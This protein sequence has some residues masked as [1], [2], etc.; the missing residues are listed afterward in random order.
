MQEGEQS[1]FTFTSREA[2]GPVAA[3]A[4]SFPCRPARPSS[5]PARQPAGR[6]AS[7]G[8]PLPSRA[9][10]SRRQPAR[11]GPAR[12]LTTGHGRTRHCSTR[13]GRQPDPAYPAEYA[14]LR[15]PGLRHA[16]PES[17]PPTGSTPVKGRGGAG[18]GQEAGRRGRSQRDTTAAICLP[19]ID[20]AEG[21]RGPRP[22][23]T[24]DRCIFHRGPSDV[25]WRRPRRLAGWSAPSALAN[26]DDD[27]DDARTLCPL[28]ARPHSGHTPPAAALRGNNAKRRGQHKCARPRARPG[29]ATPAP[30]FA[31]IPTTTT[32]TSPASS[33]SPTGRERRKFER[34]C[35]ALRSPRLAMHGARE[36]PRPCAPC[37]SAADRGR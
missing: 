23:D 25:A 32:T 36:S 7:A 17:G 5:Q 8:G 15:P 4:A 9:R 35:A 2:R 1:H 30:L 22:A 10:P 11:P 21:P 37:S 31:E 16:N 6:A 3:C 28:L 13:L 14:G 19:H 29:Q 18:R 33:A 24:P 20:C 12:H 26:D 34:R 27:D